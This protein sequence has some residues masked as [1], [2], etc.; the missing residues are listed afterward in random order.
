MYSNDKREVVINNENRNNIT[1]NENFLRMRH[2]YYNN[3][4]DLTDDTFVSIVI[5]GY[6]RLEKTKR[7]V[8][9][10]IKYT[11]DFN[12]ELILIDNGSTDETTDYFQTVNYKNKKIIRISKNTGALYAIHTAMKIYEGN[13]FVLLLNDVYVTDG[14]LT[15]LIRCYDSDEKI[16]FVT[17]CSS[18]VSNLQQVDLSF[19]NF[20]EM[21]I[22][23]K[24]FNKSNPLLWQERLRLINIVTMLKREVIDNVGLF[25]SG[26][27]HDFLEDDF[28]ARVRRAGYKLMLCGDTF[29]HHDHDF[30]NME[31]KDPKKYQNSL[32]T[33]RKNYKEKYY[34]LDA[35]DDIN[36]YELN[37]IGMLKNSDKSVKEPD[38][39]GI[40]VRCGTP[41]LEIRN[42]LRKSGVFK[43]NATAYTTN[44]KYYQDLLFVTEGNVKCDR[45]EFI[46]EHFVMN[47]FDYIVIGEP[48]NTY[49]EP[50]KLIQKIIE[51]AKPGAKIL[52]KLRNV[53]DVR[54]FLKTAGANQLA[55]QDMPIYISPE[56]FINCLRAMGVNNIDIKPEYHNIDDGTLSELNKIVKN[57][58][59]S[60][61]ISK[62]V[63]DMCTNEYLFCIQK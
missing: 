22:K 24:E 23:A 46:H 38:I 7:C 53:A 15:N 43:S 8:E 12:Y 60:K 58:N 17:A 59:I 52:F 31:D 2:Q 1:E 13:Y 10:V 50:I 30:R 27:F 62:A 48:V 44:A 35:W 45:I 54:M 57:I 41:I 33:G 3:E 16:G 55:D 32:E 6:N 47:G 28:S 56:D 61:N 29:V 49:S 11:A 37:L 18:N 51:L 19:K 21:Q 39:L 63:N 14:W 25:D 36:N 40:D 42:R 34:G 9:S 20:D 26:F 4:V 5:I